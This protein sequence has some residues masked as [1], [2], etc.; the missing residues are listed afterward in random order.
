MLPMGLQPGCTSPLATNYMANATLDDGSCV[1]PVT[2]ARIPGCTYTA[3]IVPFNPAATVDDGSCVFA[4]VASLVTALDDT[5]NTAQAC[6]TS[7][8]LTVQQVAQCNA[9][10]LGTADQLCSNASTLTLARC[11]STVA[12][13][14]ASLATANASISALQA[15][16]ASCMSA[17]AASNVTSANATACACNAMAANAT[18]DAALVAAQTALAACQTG[19]VANSS[20]ATLDAV[21]ANATITTLQTSVA[22]LTSV[23]AA[24]SA[25]ISALL[26]DNSTAVCT[27]TLET[28]NATVRQLDASTR[29]MTAALA[30]QAA[31]IA[32]LSSSNATAS[33]LATIAS[34]NG[35]VAGL[36]GQLVNLT[37]VVAL[38]AASVTQLYS[39]LAAALQNSSSLA[40]RAD[41]CDAT[42]TATAAQL[43]AALHDVV[44][45]SAALISSDRNASEL[46]TGLAACQAGSADVNATLQDALARVDNLTAVEAEQRITISLLQSALTNASAG[47]SLQLI[48]DLAACQAQATSQTTTIAALQSQV[49]ALAA[50]NAGLTSR[51]AAAE[52]NASLA[53]AAVS[54][55]VDVAAS[56]N[57]TLALTL[58]AVATRI[59]AHLGSVGVL[60]PTDIDELLPTLWAQLD[61][62]DAA[63]QEH[64]ASATQCLTDA[65]AMQNVIGDQNRTISVQ[66]AVIQHLNQTIIAMSAASMCSCG[67]GGAGTGSTSGTSSGGGGGSCSGGSSGSSGGSGGGGS[68]AGSTGSGSTGSGSTPSGGASTNSTANATTSGG[69]ATTTGGGSTVGSSSLT[70]MPVL[71]LQE[72]CTDLHAS[73][74]NVTATV[75]D[76]PVSLCGTNATLSELAAATT[77]LEMRQS[78]TAALQLPL[79][80]TQLTQITDVSAH[81]VW[82]FNA[83][84]PGNGAAAP[85][86]RRLTGTNGACPFTLR[87]RLT[88]ADVLPTADVAIALARLDTL[89]PVELFNVFIGLHP[90][91]FPN[92]S[93]TTFVTQHVTVSVSNPQTTIINNNYATYTLTHIV[94]AIAAA[95]CATGFCCCCVVGGGLCCRRQ[96]R[97]H[98]EDKTTQ[99]RRTLLDA[100]AALRA[101]TAQTGGVGSVWDSK[102]DLKLHSNP[103]ARPPGKSA[104]GPTAIS[105]AHADGMVA[106]TAVTGNGSGR[107]AHT[108]AGHPCDPIHDVTTSSN[109]LAR[110]RG[111]VKPAP[112]GALMAAPGKTAVAPV[113]SAPV[114]DEHST[115]SGVEHCTLRSD[116]TEGSIV[117]V[118]ATVDVQGAAGS[119]AASTGSAR[120]PSTIAPIARPLTG[121]ASAASASAT[122]GC[123][124]T[125]TDVLAPARHELEAAALA[126]AK[127]ADVLS[128]DA[129]T[130]DASAGV[131]TAQADPAVDSDRTLAI[132]VSAHDRG[133]VARVPA[134]VSILLT[135]RSGSMT[136]ATRAAG[137]ISGPTALPI[138]NTGYVAPKPVTS[139]RWSR[140]PTRKQ[141]GQQLAG[142]DGA[143][144]VLADD[145][146]AL[147]HA[148]GEHRKTA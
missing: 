39:Q 148:V 126:E 9:V 17:A 110:G 146:A 22:N 60:V 134:D 69:G 67:S 5:N 91:L 106:H 6:L 107:T 125:A 72:M 112:G 53:T 68:G 116:R 75:V 70:S 45:L 131:G 66:S 8:D 12:S 65:H 4:D 118:H 15:S 129:V 51:V 71:A 41:G 122:H 26:A 62:L 74:A 81:A 32:L 99:K 86:R 56:W 111:D 50:A 97:K 37:Q 57:A 93:A 127:T 98:E 137:S 18:S 54:R 59:N 61:G 64:N 82:N 95:V 77:V 120:Q 145:V 94:V 143:T 87:F 109:P 73:V 133:N 124:S 103:L 76:Y 47:S 123:A 114:L 144:D 24:Q 84:S 20:R 121:T 135:A 35:T 28:L 89:P 21:A 101:R 79:F 115:D 11:Q 78:I 49:S 90:E 44:V 23:V 19:A 138:T 140:Q 42:A 104:F 2:P 7:L 96:Q 142:D 40:T 1:Y 29:N 16:L 88:L 119:K 80:T 43:T 30:S 139:G 63:Q 48:A 13:L 100:K 14:N 27:S 113:S 46:S 141:Y 38:Q 55:V 33:M 147:V 130:N 31:T 132:A 34:L 136:T 117:P 102:H 83:S 108:A 105:A 10:L 36:Q 92:V 58:R 3:S 52:S 85:A 128:V 25:R